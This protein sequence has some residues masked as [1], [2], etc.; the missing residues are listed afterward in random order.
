MADDIDQQIKSKIQAFAVEL[1]A[2]VRQAAVA[3]VAQA[4]GSGRAPAKRGPGRPAKAASAAAPAK[5]RPGRPAKV[6]AVSAPAAALAKRG[7]GRPKKVV[8][9]APPAA[10]AKAAAPVAKKQRG[11]KRGRRDA[12]Q[13]AAA[14]A[15]LLAY[16]KAHGGD[17]SETVRAKTGLE[18]GLFQLAVRSLVEAKK[19]S[20]KGLKRATSFT[21]A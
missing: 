21:A 10:P 16:V 17:R 1:A 20:S 18:K 12:T 11:G 9:I 6:A 14:A 3:A 7:P 13:I 2:L 8:A 19:I 5:R 4:L 15:N